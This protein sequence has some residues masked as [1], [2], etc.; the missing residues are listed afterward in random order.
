MPPRAGLLPGTWK[1]IDPSRLGGI[2]DRPRAPARWSAR[3]VGMRLIEAHRIL[4][5]LRGGHAGAFVSA[6]ARDIG[7]F[8]RFRLNACGLVPG[9]RDRLGVLHDSLGVAELGCQPALL[10]IALIAFL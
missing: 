4:K 5:R 7:D 6:H 1:M 3:H 2:V 8:R 10:G 9:G